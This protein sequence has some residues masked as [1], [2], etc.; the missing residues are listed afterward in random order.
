[1]RERPEDIAPNIAFERARVEKLLGSRVTFNADA[2]AAYERFATDPGTL[3]PGNFRD[4]GASVQ[5]MCTLAPR[6]RITPAMVETEIATIR[7]TWAA[8]N[9]DPDMQLIARYLGS[10]AAQIDEFDRVQLAAV[11]RI[12][13]ISASLSAAGR[14]L[15]A[16]SRAAKT[17]RNDADRLRKYLDRF[18]LDWANCT[19]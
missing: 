8:A 2:Q 6:G 5:R 19:N 9:T 3:W 15:F 16:A 13:Q 18:R 1:M 14:R 17:S 11:I 7:G 4:L 12:C 10:K